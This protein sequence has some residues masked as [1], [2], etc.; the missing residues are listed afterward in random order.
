M[1]WFVMQQELTNKHMHRNMQACT[2][3]ALCIYAPART[4][5]LF[6]ASTFSNTNARLP[7]EAFIGDDSESETLS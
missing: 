6:C 4:R 2:Q 1:G 5:A 7:T 3:T